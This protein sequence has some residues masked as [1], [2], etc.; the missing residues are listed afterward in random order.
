[1]ADFLAA[2]GPLLTRSEMRN[3]ARV[4]GHILEVGP[5]SRNPVVK[6][7]GLLSGHDVMKEL[8]IGPGPLV[9]AVLKSVALAEAR[10]SVKT[11]EEALKLARA[12][13]ETGAVVG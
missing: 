9:G 4:I 11:R 6:R 13:I 3:Q 7:R 1:M 2:R 8:Q 12:S 5:Q 10:G